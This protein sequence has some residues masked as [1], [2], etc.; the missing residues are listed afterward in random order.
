MEKTK[1]EFGRFRTITDLAE[2]DKFDEILA[3]VIE[4]N[5][6]K[7]ND[8]CYKK[9]LM[10]YPTNLLQL[11]FDYIEEIVPSSEIG[12]DK[13]KVFLSYEKLFNGYGI[14]RYDG[15]GVIMKIYKLS[16]NGDWEFLLQI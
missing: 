11:F 1:F 4:K 16:E 12:I 15:L 3:R 10:P 9:G 6:E 5:G 8:S 13:D 2:T 14:L 7:W